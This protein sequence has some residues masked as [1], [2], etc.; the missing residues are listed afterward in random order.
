[1]VFSQLFAHKKPHSFPIFSLHDTLIYCILRKK[2]ERNT[3]KVK[4]CGKFHVSLTVP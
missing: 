4:N 1:M 3:E 2:K